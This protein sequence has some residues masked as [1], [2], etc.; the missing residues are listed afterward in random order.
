MKKL[1]YRA[2]LV[3]AVL[4]VA[5]VATPKSADA[6]GWGFSITSGYPGYYGRSPGYYARSPGYYSH[7]YSYLGPPRYNYYPRRAYYPGFY[8]PGRGYGHHHHH[9]H[10]HH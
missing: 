3:V 10:G 4:G 1:T 7:G 8:G 6:A 9:H 5:A 2:L